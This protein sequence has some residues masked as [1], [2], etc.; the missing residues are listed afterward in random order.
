MSY[1]V[2]VVCVSFDCCFMYLA[3]IGYVCVCVFFGGES[4]GE[5]S[6]ATCVLLK[7]NA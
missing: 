2:V 1:I 7:H 4:L 3:R 6:T 5:M